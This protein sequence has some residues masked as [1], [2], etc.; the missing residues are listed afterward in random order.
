MRFIPADE[1]IRRMQCRGQCTLQ[2]VLP[3]SPVVS[4]CDD[5]RVIERKWGEGRELFTAILQ[6]SRNFE[7]IAAANRDSRAGRDSRY[8]VTAVNRRAGV[9]AVDSGPDE[10]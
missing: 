6:G 7:K 8:D 5:Q 2:G 4:A 1:T 3:W 10:K 9:G